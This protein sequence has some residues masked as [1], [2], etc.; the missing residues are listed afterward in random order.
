MDHNEYEVPMTAQSLGAQQKTLK[1]LF[2]RLGMG[3][4]AAYWVCVMMLMME[5]GFQSSWSLYVVVS[6]MSGVLVHIYRFLQAYLEYSMTVHDHL[7]QSR[8]MM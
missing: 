3:I 7:L 8:V 5:T 6:C 4:F 1:V 2:P